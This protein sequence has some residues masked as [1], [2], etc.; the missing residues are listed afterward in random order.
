MRSLP[1]LPAVEY[2]EQ[3]PGVQERFGQ[4]WN[5]HAICGDERILVDYSCG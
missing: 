1:Q 2:S 3:F 4:D 5:Y